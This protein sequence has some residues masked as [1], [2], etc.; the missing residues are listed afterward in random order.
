MRSGDSGPRNPEAAAAGRTA[1]LAASRRDLVFRT[2]FASLVVSIAAC[3]GIAFAGGPAVLEAGRFRPLVEAFNRA[4]EKL[5]EELHPVSIPNRAAWDY[6]AANVPLFECP[7]EDITEIYWFRW[8]SWRKHVRRTPD[9]TII[10]EFL[11]AVSWA[12]RH[13][14]ISCAAGHHFY[15]GRWLRDRRVLDDYATFWFRRGGEPRR[16]SFWAADAVRARCLVSGDWTIAVDLLPDLVENYRQWERSNLDSNGL[17]WQIDDRDGMELSIG[18]SGY[19]ATINSYQYGDALAIARIAEAAGRPEIACEF[20][21]KAATIRRLVQ[22][23]LWDPRAQFFKVLPRGDAAEQA[24]VRELHGFTPWYF[25]LPDPDKAVAW[26]Q[27]TDP[28][29]FNA[30]FGPTSAERRHPGFTISREGHECQ[31]N[32]P[33]WPFSTAVTLTALANLLDGPP[34]DAVTVRDYF[35]TLRTYTKSH[36]LRHDDG[37]VVPWIDENLDPLTGEWLARSMRSARAR[38]NRDA[39]VRVELGK[40]YNH[41]TYCDLVITGLVGLRPRDDDVVEVHPLVPEGT[42]DYFCLDDVPYHGRSLTILFD[43]TGDRYRRGPGLRV[44][45]D[46]REIAAA[47]RL[48]RVTGRLIPIGRE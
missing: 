42:W 1:G 27:L 29:G 47:E 26:K 12:G 10:D 34:Q 30:P 45:S 35:E 44:L 48:E 28:A 6:L 3:G 32:G 4:D 15:E 13:N 46:G 43:R 16:Y 31:W 40:D 41:S 18:G 19:R 37:H 22:E 17:F 5:H 2:A 7:D 8:W 11:P 25:N 38:A 39:A 20:R 21:D 14:S 24:D 33:S 9:G 36:R 23:R